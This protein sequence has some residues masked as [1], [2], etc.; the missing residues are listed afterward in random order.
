MGRWQVYFS[1]FLLL[2]IVVR[3]FQYIADCHDRFRRNLLYRELNA[4]LVI[5]PDGVNCT[6]C[7]YIFHKGS[8]RQ[9]A[10]NPIAFTSTFG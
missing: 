4:V 2:F 6:E 3:Q 9:F 10:G 1:I 5:Y 8:S 7:R